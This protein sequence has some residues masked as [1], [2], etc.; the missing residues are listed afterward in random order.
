MELLKSI[1]MLLGGLGVFLVGL[2]MMGDSLESM[3]GDKLKKLFNKISNNRFAGVSIGAATTMVI[4]S[5][6]AT[7]VMVVGFVNAGVFTL[8]QATAIIMGANI[9]TTIT[10]W[11]SSFQN[12]PITAFCAALA[13]VG[14]FMMLSKKNN[15]RSIGCALAGIGSIFVGLSVMSSSMKMLQSNQ[16]VVDLFA[17]TKNAFVLLLL[18]ASITAI[19]QSSSA[20]TSILITLGSTGLMSLDNALFVTLGINIGTCVTAL[21]AS[22]GANTNAKRASLIHLLFNCIGSLIFFIFTIST[23]MAD[24]IRAI[25]PGDN[26]VGM[27]IALFHTVFNITT[28][29]LLLPFVKQLTG[30]ATIIIKDKKP[31]K[32]AEKDTVCQLKYLDDRLIA[33]PTIALLM[34]RKEIINMAEIAKI[35]LDVAIKTITTLELSEY[36]EFDKRETFIN[37]ANSSITKYLVNI[38]SENISY[39]HE[40]ELSTYY[41][42][43]SDLERVGD[44]AENIM[45]YSKSLINHNANFS[46]IAITKILDMKEKINELYSVVLDGFNN[47]DIS[48][49]AL[50]NK[51]EDSID[52]CRENFA[53]EHITRLENQLC[54]AEAGSVFLSLINNMERI[55]DHICNVFL[56]MKSYVHAPTKQPANIKA[57]PKKSN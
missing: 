26:S 1:L 36:D 34:A 45:E 8:T 5:S 21:L 6:S 52:D 11:I 40:K 44:Y 55:A 41:H 54:T 43:L 51:I 27:Q 4:Q 32:V 42:V 28:T 18:G 3:A 35:N 56:S 2:K 29:L 48:N 10:G 15:I 24:W 53:K 23:P 38:S 57:N 25:L 47:K 9:G 19:I 31:K 12:L 33:T 13:C 46:D 16:G 50:M 49:L 20:T 37:F 39:N 30:L 7:T 22:I 17:N 14:A